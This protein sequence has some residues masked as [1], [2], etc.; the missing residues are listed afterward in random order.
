MAERE[1]LIGLLREA[2]NLHDGIC[3][4]IGRKRVEEIADNLLAHGVTIPVRCKECR[5]YNPDGE[6][7]GNWG[8][9]RHPEHFCDEGLEEGK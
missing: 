3:R 8:E 5:Y 1:K 7:C 2:I 9:V 6:Y 4:V